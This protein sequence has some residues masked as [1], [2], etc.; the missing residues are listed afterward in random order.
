MRWIMRVLLVLVAT[1]AVGIIVAEV[2]LADAL[3]RVQQARVPTVQFVDGFGAPAACARTAIPTSVEAFAD[4]METVGASD[5]RVFVR[6]QYRCADGVQRTALLAMLRNAA[7]AGSGTAQPLLDAITEDACRTMLDAS[8]TEPFAIGTLAAACALAVPRADGS[9]VRVATND[10]V[11]RTFR[12]A[13]HL[14]LIR[15]GT[16]SPDVIVQFCEDILHV[17]PRAYLQISSVYDGI[18]A[19]NMAYCKEE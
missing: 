17:S 8:G 2:F 11:V 12:F 10:E 13:Q 15:A 5:P 16:A 9:V 14:A 6:D 19:L 18:G 4:A 3:P 7:R 1:L